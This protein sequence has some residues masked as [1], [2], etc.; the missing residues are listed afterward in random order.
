M[1]NVV[2]IY[3]MQCHYSCTM[4]VTAESASSNDNDFE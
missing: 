3:H 4:Q 1:S 2:N